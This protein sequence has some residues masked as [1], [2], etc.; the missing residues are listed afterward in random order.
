MPEASFHKHCVLR[1]LLSMNHGVV[2]NEWCIMFTSNYSPSS[3]K[4]ETDF[5]PQDGVATVAVAA[6]IRASLSFILCG[7]VAS[8]MS[9]GSL[10]DTA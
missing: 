3:S 9:A 5:Q 2:F 6:G 1:M 8:S 10:S 4:E 7:L